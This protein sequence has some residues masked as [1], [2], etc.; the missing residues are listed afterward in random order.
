MVKNINNV[1]FLK[2]IFLKYFEN[3]K[4]INNGDFNINI[5]FE[6]FYEYTIA[7]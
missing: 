6:I 5:I 2:K 4:N 1:D 7:P 3:V